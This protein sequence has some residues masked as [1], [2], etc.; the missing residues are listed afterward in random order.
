MPPCCTNCS[1]KRQFSDLASRATR[2]ITLYLR[3]RSYTVLHRTV[4]YFY[5]TVL[6][7]RYCIVLY[8]CVLHYAELLW[9]YYTVLDCTMLFFTELCCTLLDRVFLLYYTEMHCTVLCFAF[10]FFTVLYCIILFLSVLCL[11]CPRSGRNRPTS[12]RVLAVNEIGL[13]NEFR[14]KTGNGTVQCPGFE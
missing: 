7:I 6:F 4:Q 10:L 5:L 9:H 12:L 8:C 11:F 1:S 3:I 13:S 14:A 2:E